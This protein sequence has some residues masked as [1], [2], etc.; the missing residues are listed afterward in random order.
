[1][2]GHACKAYPTLF[3]FHLVS[4]DEN[5]RSFRGLL[6]IQTHIQ[7]ELFPGTPSKQILSKREEKILLE[8][9][10]DVNIERPIFQESDGKNLRFS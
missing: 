4:T 1:M 3:R 10:F 5:T 2:D 9:N 6:N 8:M 7:R